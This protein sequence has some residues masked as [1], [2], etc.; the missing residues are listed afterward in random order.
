MES[1]RRRYGAEIGFGPSTAPAAASIVATVRVQL[2]VTRA[3]FRLPTCKMTQSPA[4]SAVSRPPT[5]SPFR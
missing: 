3:N 5:F 2:S 4:L 1:L